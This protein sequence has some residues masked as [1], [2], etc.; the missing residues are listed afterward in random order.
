M[1]NKESTPKETPIEEIIINVITKI[2]NCETNYT[3]NSDYKY[4]IEDVF[5]KDITDRLKSLEDYRALYFILEYDSNSE[6][7]KFIENC[8]EIKFIQIYIVNRYFNHKYNEPYSKEK[9]IQKINKINGPLKY[10]IQII[11]NLTELIGELYKK[12]EQLEEGNKDLKKE[13]LQKSKYLQ[14]QIGSIYKEFEKNKTLQTKCDTL[15][16][17]NA[18]LR[19]RVKI[20]DESNF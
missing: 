4:T 1:G 5:T 8:Q 18:K 16:E 17:E 12:I 9:L 15:E 7:T 3:T 2:S 11:C 13:Y 10:S 19:E 14:M 6:S 20:L